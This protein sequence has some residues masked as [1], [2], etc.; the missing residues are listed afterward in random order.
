MKKNLKKI[1]AMLLALTMVVGMTACGGGSENGGGT[2]NGGNAGSNKPASTTPLVVGTSTL[3]QKFSPFTADTQ[4]DRDIADLTQ[5]SLMTT[6]RLGGIIKNA[7]EGE[8]VSYNGTDYKYTGAAN[9][10][11][12]YDEGTNVTTYTAKLRDDLKFSDGEPVTADDI[13][14]TYYVYLDNS[15]VGSTTLNSYNIVGLKNYQ[16]NSTAAEGV[17]V[18]DEQIADLLANPSD[19]LTEVI[20]NKITAILTEEMEWCGGVYEERGAE[21]QVA[22]FIQCYALEDGYAEEDAD[23]ALADVIAQ[24]GLNYKELASRYAGDE[25]YFDGEIVGAAQQELFDAA[26]AAAGG[27]EVPNIQVSTKLMT[28]Q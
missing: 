25:T 5:I 18:T 15:Y 6:D 28:T 24:Y 2:N 22:F 8:T 7:I 10:D 3:S 19:A 14:F 9:I 16:A 23:K 4:Y 17:E 20:K 1:L 11:W 21:S 12:V 26:V 13:I 27:E